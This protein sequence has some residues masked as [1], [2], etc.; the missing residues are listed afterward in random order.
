MLLCQLVVWG[1]PEIN[2]GRHPSPIRYS[3]GPSESI[4]CGGRLYLPGIELWGPM[5]KRYCVLQCP[6]APSPPLIVGLM[7]YGR[8][9]RLFII[10]GGDAPLP[11]TPIAR[12][13]WGRCSR[14][15]AALGICSA[16]ASHSL[17]SRG[18]CSAPLENPH[19]HTSTAQPSSRVT[20]ALDP[21]PS[22]CC[23]W[24]SFDSV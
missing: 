13:H 7:R 24:P 1:S 2:C 14:V 23:Y 8:A 5:R 12:T 17:N 11:R 3:I 18:A 22:L 9:I 16:R 15:N 21:W 6:H 19:R 10:F 20:S 4:G